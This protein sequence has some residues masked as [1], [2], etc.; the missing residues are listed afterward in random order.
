M[1]AQEIK[2]MTTRDARRYPKSLALIKLKIV[3]P[4][5]SGGTNFSVNDTD[6][7]IATSRQ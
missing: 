3:K 5:T 1:A 4:Q 6:L 7:F 2:P